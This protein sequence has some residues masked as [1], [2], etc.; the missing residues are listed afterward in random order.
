M[1]PEV[2]EVRRELRIVRDSLLLAEERPNERRYHI[3]RAYTHTE[4]AVLMLKL[5]VGEDRLLDGSESRPKFTEQNV[6]QLLDAAERLFGEGRLEES[7]LNLR[8]ARDAL[9]VRLKEAQK[10][11][12]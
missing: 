3:W 1:K 7:L 6:E 10:Q 8:K 9:I 2:S 11:N 12:L 4:L 5:A